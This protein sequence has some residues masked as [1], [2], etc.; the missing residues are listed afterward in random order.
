MKRPSARAIRGVLRPA[1]VC[2]GLAAS[3]E[4]PG[5]VR[6]SNTPADEARAG[7][8]GTAADRLVARI[9][10]IAAQH[11]KP[12][13]FERLMRESAL[14]PNLS[15]L[16]VL[17][18]L[19]QLRRSILLRSGGSWEQASVAAREAAT[20]AAFEGVMRVQR[21]HR[22]LRA[23]GDQLLAPDRFDPLVN[24]AA[25]GFEDLSS[26]QAFL[27]EA[28]MEALAESVI[29]RTYPDEPEAVRS[30]LVDR[31]KAVLWQKGTTAKAEFRRD[32]RYI[33]FGT[34]GFGTRE[35][36]LR[37]DKPQDR[38]D[39]IDAALWR[40]LRQHPRHRR[41]LQSAYTQSVVAQ[42][43]RALA[44]TIKNVPAAPPR[45]ESR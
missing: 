21:W 16:G 26:V 25:A 11:E 42:Q 35:D 44:E 1:V 37:F 30:R 18:K 31:L 12:G 7:R 29:R 34:N 33:F 19:D 20:A 14:D 17:E 43:A 36:F 10:E 23:R 22:E 8:D 39:A 2:L 27:D 24:K 13:D 4:A 6:A 5:D 41:A 45:R 32:V 40:V 28:G 38:Q 9:R 3:S 15:A